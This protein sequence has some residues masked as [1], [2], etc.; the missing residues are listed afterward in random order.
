[1]G[2]LHLGLNSNTE[3]MFSTNLA[4][5]SRSEANMGLPEDPELE[6]NSSIEDHSSLHIQKQV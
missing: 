6:L 3:M 5:P 1:M 2:N 4:Q